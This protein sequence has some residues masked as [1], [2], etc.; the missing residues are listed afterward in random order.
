MVFRVDDG[1][2][3]SQMVFRVDDGLFENQMGFSTT[4]FDF[5][6]LSELKMAHQKSQIDS[7]VGFE[8]L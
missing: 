8:G 3:K 6:G 2:L 1:F 4:V 5:S 7:S